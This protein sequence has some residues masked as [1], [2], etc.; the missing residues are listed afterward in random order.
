M[1]EVQAGP[2]IRHGKKYRFF[3]RSIPNG[4]EN[5]NPVNLRTLL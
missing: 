1:A 4:P 5:C 2:Y 3:I